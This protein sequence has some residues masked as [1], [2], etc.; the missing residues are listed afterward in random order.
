MPADDGLA[1]T[2][3][4]MLLMSL[5]VCVVVASAQADD[6]PTSATLTPVSA[7]A[8]AVNFDE[9]PEP[10]KADAL[11]GDEKRVQR[12][13]GALAGGMVGVGAMAAFLPLAEGD[14]RFTGCVGCVS[15]GQ[16]VLG[17]AAPIVG[18]LGAWLGSFLM[19]GQAGPLTGFAAMVPALLIGVALAAIANSMDLRTGVQHVPLLVVAGAFLAGGSALALDLREQQLSRLGRAHSWGGATA[20]R[21]AVTSLTSALTATVAGFL[22]VLLGALNPIAGVIGGLV[23]GVGVA[24]ATWGVHQAMGG[25]GSFVSALSALGAGGALTFAAVGL[26]AAAQGS[27]FNT[28]RS[29]GAGILAVELGI[30]SALFLPTLALEWSHTDAIAAKLPQFSFGAAPTSQG[31]MVSAGVRF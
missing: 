8:D 25:R 29:T 31:G 10:P 30:I 17:A 9:L 13:L 3:R 16:V 7:P 22:S 4:T 19:G 11:I 6:A 20:G 15:A 23:Q 18:V 14:L 21:A 24:A 5:V 26:F 2:S 27:G 28:V 12:F 1:L